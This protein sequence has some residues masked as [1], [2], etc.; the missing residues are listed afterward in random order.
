MNDGLVKILDGNTFVVS[1]DRGD[2]EASLTDPTGLFSFDT[3]FL[4]KWV[5]TVNGQRLNAL[6]TDDLQY[7][8]TRF[9]LV[10]GTG[11]V[12]IDA[13]LSVIRQR[14]VGGGFHEEL[15]ILNHDDE[16]D[17]PHGPHR[18]RDATSPTCSRSR[19]P[20]EEGHVLEPGE[21]RPL[22]LA[23]Q[24]ETFVRAT[25]IS[26]TTPAKMDRTGLTFRVQPRSTR[27]WSTRLR[28][29]GRQPAAAAAE[30]APTCNA[31]W[32]KPRRW[33]D[34][35]PR[36]ECDWDAAE[37]DLSA[38][39]G[40]PRRAAFLTADRGGKSLP[41]AGLPWFMT[42]FGRDSIFT[43]LQACRSRPSSPRR[44]SG[45]SGNGKGPLCDDFR[46]EDP[47]PDPARDALRR[48]DRLRGAAALALLRLRRRDRPVRG[49]AGRVRA[50]DR[51]HETRAR[52][53]VR[54]A[55]GAGLDRRIRRPAAA[56]DTSR[57]SVATR[58]PVSRTSAGR[59]PGTR[60]PTPTAGCRAFR[61]RPASSRGTPTTR[62]CA[63]PV[64]PAWSGRTPLSPAGWRGRPP[65][66]N[67]GSTGTSGSPK[68]STSL[69]RSSR[70]ASRWTHS[71]RTTGICSGAASSTSRRRR[72]SPG[73][74]SAR[75][76]SPGGACA[77]S[78]KE[79]AATTR[80]ATT[81]APSGPSTTPSSPG[82]C[83][84]TASSRRRP[85][86]PPGSST[87][88]SSSRVGSRRRSAATSG[89]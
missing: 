36:L 81:S 25:T 43:S 88:P 83:A 16:A 61:G 33:L 50:L 24:R 37:G 57:T 18:G 8:E 72:P 42:M 19:T 35:A 7:F 46:D 58:R 74:S 53:G 4:S 28:R 80:S 70:T 17:R 9:F 22:V 13:K 75:G 84:D 54:G 55:R 60:S 69:W 59:T 20:Q 65:T 29:G 86:S 30:S 10:P 78:R 79:R 12:Y 62:R 49:P 89:P 32:S 63:A 1:D 76:S 34:A 56:T 14:A 45:R 2:I 47:G 71:P 27:R 44:R 82:A 40:R 39:P 15:T 87:P 38:E 41:A 77:R 52:P 66:S 31:I 67:A 64:S 5:L 48:D 85:A 6:S 68:G 23:Y 3:R 51:R 73:T 21:G 26:A 11:T